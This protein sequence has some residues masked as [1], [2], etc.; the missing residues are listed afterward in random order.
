MYVYANASP[1][2]SCKMRPDT[3]LP[4]NFF[5]FQAKVRVCTRKIVVVRW[6]LYRCR[7]LINQNRK[8][9]SQKRLFT[10]GACRQL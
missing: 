9:F 4:L 8:D 5:R 3:L 7:S 6:G 10:L 2:K 1:A